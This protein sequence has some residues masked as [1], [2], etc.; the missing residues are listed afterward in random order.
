[1]KSSKHFNELQ[2]EYLEKI[3]DSFKIKR[4][5]EKEVVAQKDDKCKNNIF[6]VIEGQYELT[7]PDAKAEFYGH[8]SMLDKNDDL[9]YGFDMKFTT[10]G[11]VASTTKKEIESALGCSLEKAQMKSK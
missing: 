9:K 6:F 2:T 4:V 3:I 8:E 1:M 5:S 7:K 10:D 11:K